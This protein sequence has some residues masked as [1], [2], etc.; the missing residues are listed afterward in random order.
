FR[1]VGSS[2]SI[3]GPLI[4]VN[5]AITESLDF[6]ATKLEQSVASGKTL[7]ASI[8]A[9]LTEIAKES[10]AVCFNGN[11]YSAEWHAEAEKRGLPNLKTS[12]EA[13][14]V[15]EKPEVIQAFEKYGILSPRELHSRYEIYVEQYVKT[16]LV[17]AKLTS[18]MAKTQI[19]P[20]AL[21]YAKELAGTLPA[22]GKLSEQ[23]SGLVAD[24]DKGITA[25]D[26][27]L[28]HESSSLFD[29]AKHLR[30]KAL[31][32]MTTVRTAA[33]ALEGLIADDQ[34]P[35]PTYQEMLFIR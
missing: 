15:L 23:I 18:K 20:A 4:A 27:A 32:A 14:P 2:Q 33:D 7:N 31:S 35:L 21:R 24:L 11:G 8:Q 3:T 6:I 9:L 29:E 1:A 10:L 25:L 22:G 16:V 30:D 19:L 12:I 28:A 13:L 26:G 17:E 5:T 34:W